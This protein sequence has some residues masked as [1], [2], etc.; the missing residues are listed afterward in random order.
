MV[1]DTLRTRRRTAL[2]RP[3]RNSVTASFA[4]AAASRPARIAYITIGAAGL[5]ALA[6][7]L[8]GPRRIERQIRPLIDPLRDALEPRAEKL[9][10]DSR[11]LRDQIANLLGRATPSSRERLVRNFQSWIGHFRAT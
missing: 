3:A 10:D 7:A 5:A 2:E 9:W 8:I 6:V 11:Q 4:R 1:R